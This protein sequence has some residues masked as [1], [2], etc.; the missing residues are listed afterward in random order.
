[1]SFILEIS[2]LTSLKNWDRW[3]FTKINQDWTNSFLDNIF[4]LWRE[5]IT[6]LPLYVFLGIFVFLNFGQKAWPWVLALVFTVI[7]TDQA[8]SHIFKPLANR[9]RPCHDPLLSD[10]IRLLLQYCSDSAGF[11]SSHATNHFGL[12]FFIYHTLKS[13]FG[14][15]GYLFFFWAAT[16]SYGQVYIGVHYPLDV[17][18]G[19]L[20]GS[21]I[22]YFMSKQF[23]KRFGLLPLISKSPAIGV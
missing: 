8:S 9:P 21:C 13:Y 20:I 23:N 14:K 12:A 22:G 7:L 5:A 16:I 19:A 17:I 11:T 10:H 18:C 15:W 3:L 1:M 2:I 6:W 4:P